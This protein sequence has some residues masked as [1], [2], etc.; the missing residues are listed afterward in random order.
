[1]KFENRYYID[2]DMYKEFVYKVATKKIT[3][4]AL[5]ILFIAIVSFFIFRDDSFET[6]ISIVV[7]IISIGMIILTPPLYLKQLLDLDNKLHN[8][9]RPEA[10][11]TF[12]DKI[13]LEEGKQKISI[14][15]AQIKKYYRLKKCSVLMFSEQNGILFVEDKFTIGTKE[16]F[17]KFILEKCNNLDK[18]ITR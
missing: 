7:G 9:Q 13:T 11:V 15:Y 16:E 8:G 10:V 12:D 6:T 3:I 2:K 14:E 4:G 17:E 1:M 5:I 18:I